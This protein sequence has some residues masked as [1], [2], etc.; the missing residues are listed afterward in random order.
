MDKLR[1]RGGKKL[2]GTVQVGGAKN[3]ALPILFSSL[4]TDETCT[5][6]QMPE[7]QDIESTVA[8]LEHLG[9]QVKREDHVAHVKS[10]VKLGTHAPYDLVRKMRASVLTLGPLLARY[11]Q[12]EVSLPGGCAI[13]ARPINLH[14]AGM[15]K[16]GA[17]IELEQGYVRAQAK[18]LVGNRV[19]FEMP[20]VGATEN[21]L[22]AAVLAKGESVLENCAR[23]PEIV[24]LAQALRAM[25]AKIEGEGSEQIR[26][27]G[28]SALKGCRYRVMGD[29]I[30]AGTYLAAGFITRGKVR[31]NGLDYQNY[32]AVLERFEAA[33]AKIQR[34]ADGVELDGSGRAQ[35]VDVTTLPYPGF[36]TDMQAQFM[37]V[38]CTADG[39]SMITE[40]IFE[41]RFMHVPELQRLGADIT[42]RGKSALVR[43]KEKLIGAPLMAT[44]LRASASLVL[45]GLCAEGETVVN[46]VYHLDRGYER[47]EEKLRSL[48]ADV[49]RIQ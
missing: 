10:G 45:G 46:R 21:V 18:A 14:L 33:G 4:L 37:A 17:K 35:G 34:H 42:I 20:S 3:A 25:G 26:V 2:L 12:A 27:Q 38:M 23:E 24:D 13:G 8:L 48:G 28:V 11:G 39:A 32:E 22:M 5:Y 19:T 43:G 6:E 47:M 49:V 41:N 44:D 16:L 9:A 40:T 36:P 1:I 15:E 29:R 31:V 7:L 30:E